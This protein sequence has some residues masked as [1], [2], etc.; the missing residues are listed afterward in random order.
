MVTPFLVVS[1]ILLLL[2][3]R[4]LNLLNLWDREAHHLG[5]STERVH[6]S[7]IVL[8]ALVTGVAVS[9]ASI[10][11]GATALLLADLLARIIVVPT[12]LPLGAVIAIVGGPFFRWLVHRREDP[13]D[14]GND[15]NVE[16]RLCHLCRGR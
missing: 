12:E 4:A 10:M 2:W 9:V 8:C 7:V 15:T 6:L 13:G 11:G 1:L 5:V 3:D 14:V 16:D